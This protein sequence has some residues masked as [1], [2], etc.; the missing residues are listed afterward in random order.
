MAL[1]LAVS[2]VAL[3]FGVSAAPQA[4]L[5]A[6]VPCTNCYRPALNTPWQWQ[7][8]GTVD[9][10]LNVAMYDIDLVDND[11]SVI[12]TLHGRGI[13]VICYIS[14][15]SWEDWRPDASQFPESVKGRN[16]GWPGE[17]WLDIR[18]IAILGPIMEARLDLCKSKGF[19][20]VEFDNVDGYSNR[21]GFPLTY[22]DQLNY[23]I[24]LANEAHER[25]L[26]AA[27]KN[28]IEQVFDLQPYFDYTL[29]EQ[30]FQYRE[31]DYGQNSLVTN[32][33]S[34]GK[35]VFQ[36]E[37]KLKT[38]QFCPQANTW[39]FN[40]MKKTYDLDAWRQSCR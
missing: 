37:Y 11:V 25:S 39:N 24:Y 5:P 14:A 27:L 20:G 22:Q 30:C 36:V 3:T 16:N 2:L 32:F 1:V 8:T 35:A 6:P 38:S 29:N 19:D 9:T 7:L 13:K 33:I 31:C 23:N 17:K 15:G 10:S 26:S 40:S 18:Q 4:A 21:T 12:N 28:D 34:N